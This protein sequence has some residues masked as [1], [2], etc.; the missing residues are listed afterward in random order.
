MTC[1]QLLIDTIRY[2]VSSQYY[3]QQRQVWPV[4]YWVLSFITKNINIIKNKSHT[5][6]LKWRIQTTEWNCNNGF[7]KT[8]LN[9]LQRIKIIPSSNCSITDF[10]GCEEPQINRESETNPHFNRIVYEEPNN[11][12]PTRTF[13]RQKSDILLFL[14]GMR[15]LAK[16]TAT[17]LKMTQGGCIVHGI[18]VKRPINPPEWNQALYIFFL[19]SRFHSGSQFLPEFHKKSETQWGDSK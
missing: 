9:C 18:K 6:N 15:K 13:N 8:L 5:Y 4:V 17:G 12:T 16:A 11:K 19:F 3:V 2:L 7:V 10:K 14:Q 1:D